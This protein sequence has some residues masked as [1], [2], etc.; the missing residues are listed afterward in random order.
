V[1]PRRQTADIKRVSLKNCKKLAAEFLPQ[2]Q[3][4]F[5]KLPQFF[6]LALAA[7]YMRHGQSWLGSHK[8]SDEANAKPECRWGKYY[9][10]EITTTLL[11][12]GTANRFFTS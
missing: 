5:Q 12:N 8:R 6:T 4:D 2:R 10:L 7:S 3:P 9:F 11:G 1:F